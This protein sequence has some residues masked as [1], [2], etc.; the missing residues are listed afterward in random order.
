MVLLPNHVLAR[1]RNART[2]RTS[3]WQS[4]DRRDH[5][6][7]GRGNAAG[8]DVATLEGCAAAFCADRAIPLSIIS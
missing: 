1:A 8:E 5:A 4:D 2:S 3:V 6:A 7:F